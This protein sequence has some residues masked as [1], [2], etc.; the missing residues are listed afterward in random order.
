MSVSQKIEIK[1][2]LNMAAASAI[3]PL[4]WPPTPPL[5][6][7]PPP[8]PPAALLLL[9][10]V[11][12]IISPPQSAMEWREKVFSPP[13]RSGGGGGGG[14]RTH[15]TRER[16]GSVGTDSPLLCSPFLSLFKAAAAAAAQVWKRREG[17]AGGRED[18]FGSSHVSSLAC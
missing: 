11:V 8:P 3:S 12:V 9:V 2:H 6:P 14:G 13:S 18:A 10:V 15:E 5:R 4:L 16:D 17:R 7:P 1:N